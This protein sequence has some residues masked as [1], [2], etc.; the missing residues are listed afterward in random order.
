MPRAVCGKAL[1]T[2][3]HLGK[4]P[5]TFDFGYPVCDVSR[6]LAAHEAG[7]PLGSVAGKLGSA[8]NTVQP[9]ISTEMLS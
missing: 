3:S 8:R 5:M 1:V 4:C 9:N 2:D 7:Q 6:P